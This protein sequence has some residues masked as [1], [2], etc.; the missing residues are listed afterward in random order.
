MSGPSAETLAQVAAIPVDEFLGAVAVSIAQRLSMAPAHEQSAAL[1]TL[2]SG[3]FVKL[4]A[5]AMT[6]NCPDCAEKR[7]VAAN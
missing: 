4:I 5:Q 1:L 3:A 7:A 2:G 6:C